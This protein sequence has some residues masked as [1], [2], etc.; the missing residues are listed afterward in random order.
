MNKINLFTEKQ[1]QWLRKQVLAATL[2]STI[3]SIVSFVVAIG[4]YAPLGN[5]KDYRNALVVVIGLT[6][7]I[8]FHKVILKDRKIPNPLEYV[9]YAAAK[10][11]GV[12]YEMILNR[13]SSHWKEFPLYYLAIAIVPYVLIVLVMTLP[14]S[15][16][17]DPKYFS[18]ALFGFGAG[19]FLSD[20]VFFIHVL[21]N[22]HK[23]P[24]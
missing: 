21:L 18:E 9:G 15:Q 20:S 12:T 11:L 4:G 24:L 13:M 16:V 14:A 8:L 5:I 10:S 2:E 7:G 19:I 3:I 17:S 6:T 1:L 23:Q 22:W